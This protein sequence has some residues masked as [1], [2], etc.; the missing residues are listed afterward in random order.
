MRRFSKFWALV[1]LLSWIKN[2]SNIQSRVEIAMLLVP[3]TFWG[4]NSRFTCSNRKLI[5]DMKALYKMR[6]NL[7]TLAEERGA[8]SWKLHKAELQWD[9]VS[10]NCQIRSKQVSHTQAAC[11][12]KRTFFEKPSQFISILF[13]D[14]GKGISPLYSEQ[15]RAIALQTVRTTW[16]SQA[17]Q[18][19]KILNE[20]NKDS[21]LSMASFETRCSVTSM[22]GRRHIRLRTHARTP[23]VNFANSYSKILGLGLN[24]KNTKFLSEEAFSLMQSWTHHW[25]GSKIGTSTL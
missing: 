17:H 24:H 19:E 13:L 12:A 15:M 25:L 5:T 9:T 21:R 3:K 20:K 7:F 10:E 6:D 8:D 23:R 4:T 16:P 14:K 18:E 2:A 22:L 1:L 11:E